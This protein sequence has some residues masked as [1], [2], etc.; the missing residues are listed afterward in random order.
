MDEIRLAL[1]GRAVVSLSG[2]ACQT[3]LFFNR[4]LAIHTMTGCFPGVI[5]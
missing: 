4:L 1:E 2:V 3:P 5:F